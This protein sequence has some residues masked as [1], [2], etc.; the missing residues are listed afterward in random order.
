MKEYFFLFQVPLFVYSQLRGNT[1]YNVHSFFP[2]LYW[3]FGSLCLLALVPFVSLELFGEVADEG[4]CRL[5]SLPQP[6][7]LSGAAGVAVI[8]YRMKGTVRHIPEPAYR[9][10][11]EEPDECPV[12]SLIDWTLVSRSRL[13]QAASDR[14]SPRPCSSQDSASRTPWSTRT[15]NSP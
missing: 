7:A 4:S 8:G 12:P 9:D 10:M 11:E 6:G 13:A 3:F 15:R 14:R 5:S 2:S 1:S